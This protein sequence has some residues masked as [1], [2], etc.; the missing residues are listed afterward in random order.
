LH[1]GG[2]LD[3]FHAVTIT[4]CGVAVHSAYV[5]TCLLL[6][7]FCFMALNVLEPFVGTLEVIKVT[8]TL[9]AFKHLETRPLGPLP[10][11]PAAPPP[12]T[13]AYV[14]KFGAATRALLSEA[15]PPPMEPSG[16]QGPAQGFFQQSV[17]TLTQGNPLDLAAAWIAVIQI[18]LSATIS[19]YIAGRRLV[20]TAQV[21]AAMTKMKSMQEAEGEP[22]G[23]AGGEEQAEGKA[24]FLA[25]CV[26]VLGTGGKGRY[27]M[28]SR[29]GDRRDEGRL[30]AQTPET[31]DQESA[32]AE[33]SVMEPVHEWE[34]LALAPVHSQPLLEKP[35]ESERSTEGR[36]LRSTRH[37]GSNLGTDGTSQGS[38]GASKGEKDDGG[39]SSRSSKSRE[40]DDAV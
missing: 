22:E 30:V 37:C 10:P 24:S 29:K 27:V 13:Q 3:F 33:V 35:S 16:P 5:V 17:A 32:D 20:A 31:G 15:P 8:L 2:R 21:A 36:S 18:G 34:Q 4:G 25:R 11:P 9:A 7:P 40:S 23:G 12:F 28:T 1:A 19:L 6:Q 14:A 39:E 38:G 26:P